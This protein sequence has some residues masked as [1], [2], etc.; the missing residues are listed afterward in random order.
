M[1]EFRDKVLFL[2]DS[3]CRHYF[4]YAAAYL[5]ENSDIEAV[6]PDKWTSCQWKQIRYIKGAFVEKRRY[7]GRKLKAKTVH[8]N[9]G[10]H[11]IKLPDKGRGERKRALD[12]DFEIY[13]KELIESIEV[14]R[15]HERNVIFS[16]TTPN[17][18]NAGM[19]NDAD[20]VILNEIADRIMEE[21]NVPLNDLYSFVKVN[22]IIRGCISTQEQ[23]IIVIL[24]IRGGNFLVSKLHNLY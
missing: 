10:L 18:K 15:A 7:Q 20:V 5:E 6:I 12:S 2:G 3:I 22:L 11:S 24:W 8:F 4:P 1:S 19:R 17:P 9:C 21:Y 13:E 14:L 16:N 23:K